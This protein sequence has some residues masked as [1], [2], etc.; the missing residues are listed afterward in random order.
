MRGRRE[1][2]EGSESALV[3]GPL[4]PHAKPTAVSKIEQDRLCGSRLAGQIGIYC[5]LE[6]RVA[7]APVAPHAC[8]DR[9]PEI[10][11]KSHNASLQLKTP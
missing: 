10:S 6:E 3:A 4:G 11:C 7:E 1:A 8:S 9:P 5:F 2:P